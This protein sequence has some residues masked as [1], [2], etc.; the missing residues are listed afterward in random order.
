[1]DHLCYNYVKEYMDVI[2][3]SVAGIGFT[4]NWIPS[5]MEPEK[6]N[7]TPVKRDVDFAILRSVHVP[8]QEVQA[9][10]VSLQLFS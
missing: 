9:M 7:E 3:V 10:R 2:E 1:M 8:V 5:I 4:G 6:V